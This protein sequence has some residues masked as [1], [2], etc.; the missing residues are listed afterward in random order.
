MQNV[1]QVHSE[2]DRGIL[3]QIRSKVGDD[4]IVSPSYLRVALLLDPSR[5]N[6][7]FPIRKDVGGSLLTDN[8]LDQNDAF[9]ITKLGVHILIEDPAKPGTGVLLPYPNI[10]AQDGYAI[11]DHLEI[12]YN[13]YYRIKVD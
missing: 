11:P 8:K 4:K 6:Y 1:T 5:S 3:S 9:I 12:L 10:A 7:N 2:R 13:G